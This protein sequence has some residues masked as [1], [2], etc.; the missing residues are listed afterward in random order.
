MA[1]ASKL[2]SVEE[3]PGS[4]VAATVTKGPFSICVVACK[5]AVDEAD[6][7]TVFMETK[8]CNMEKEKIGKGQFSY[9]QFPSLQEKSRYKRPF[10]GKKNKLLYNTFIINFASI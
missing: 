2:D 3:V 6:K 8:I 9:F 4:V 1:L 7:M 10:K 5:V